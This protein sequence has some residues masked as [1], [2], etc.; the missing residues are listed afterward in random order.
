MLLLL[1]CYCCWMEVS[2]SLKTL[3]GQ[4][5]LLTLLH[6]FFLVAMFSH[7]IP[8]PRLK[9]LFPAEHQVLFVWLI[10]H[11][12]G[13]N[14]ARHWSFISVDVPIIRAG[15]KKLKEAILKM[16]RKSAIWFEAVICHSRAPS[17]KYDNNL[18]EIA[19]S[20]TDSQ[21]WCPSLS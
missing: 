10:L 8:N 1:Q 3:Q 4:M 17:R 15:T 2:R 14:L 11:W 18:P 13:S 12:K 19:I 16:N 5:V 21:I 20:Q 6:F 9:A 7:M